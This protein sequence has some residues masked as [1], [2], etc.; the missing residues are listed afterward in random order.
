MV[1]NPV[2]RK[3]RSSEREHLFRVAGNRIEALENEV[4]ALKNHSDA[5]QKKMDI[6]HSSLFWHLVAPLRITRETRND[7]A[8]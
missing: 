1:Q 5:L 3:E 8:T 2:K 6:L 4:A 7:G